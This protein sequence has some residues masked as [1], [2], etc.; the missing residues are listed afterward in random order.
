[1][2][3]PQLGGYLAVVVPLGLRL[4]VDP[5]QSYW[6]MGPGSLNLTFT[7]DKPMK[8][9][10]KRNPQSTEREISTEIPELN[11]DLSATTV[12]LL[13][14][15]GCVLTERDTGKGFV[16]TAVNLTTG[17]REVLA[18]RAA[19]LTTKSVHNMVEKIRQ[20]LVAGPGVIE[21]DR[22]FG[23]GVPIEKCREIMRSVFKDVLP[24][25][26]YTERKEQIS[27]A[28]HI[29]EAIHRRSVSLAEAEVGT[30]KSIGYLIPVII[31]KRSRLNSYWNMT[32]Y[33]GTPYVDMMNMPIVIATSS[34]ALQ[35]ALVD[36]VIPKLSDILLEA[37]VISR[38]IIA[39]LRKGRDHYLCRYK[40][41]SH[42]PFVEDPH[43]E[44]ILAVLNRY[45]SHVD[46]AEVDGLDNHTKRKISVPSSCSRTCPYRDSC[47]YLSFRESLESSDIDIQ[48][49]NHNYLLA[50]ALRRA[51]GG[52]PLI[53]N[54]QMVIFDEAHK[55]LSA[56]RTMYGEQFSL[57]QTLM[58]CDS[59]KTLFFDDKRVDVEIYNLSHHLGTQVRRLFL[60]LEKRLPKDPGDEASRFTVVLDKDRFR[61]L[62]NIR[63]AAENLI[64]LITSTKIVG[65]GG[66][67]S[68]QILNELRSISRMVAVLSNP[69]EQIIWLETTHKELVLHTV[70]KN[71]GKKLFD[72]LWS[73]GIPTILTS[74]TLSVGGD[75]THLR[76]M[77]GLDNLE[78]YK[79]I[80]TSQPS[81][82]NFR[83]NALTYISP[84]VLLPNQGNSDYI[85]SV[86]DEIERL[87]Y[88][89]HGH[90]VI[91]FTSYRAMD[92]VYQYLKERNLP[93]PL[94]RL[95]KGDV[96]T[97]ER[98]KESG[99]G[100]LFAA[101]SLWE[102][103]DIPGDALSLV[104]IVKLPFP[105]PDPISEYERSL[106]DSHHE[107]QQQVVLHET[108]IKTKQGQ[109]RGHRTET[110]TAVIAYLD[111]RLSPDG[112]YLAYFG[113]EV[114][115]DCQVTTDLAAV[116][117]FFNERKPLEY[118][119]T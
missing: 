76:K 45:G 24:A 58:T 35:K 79:V 81:P 65:T 10:N 118:F 14:A 102:G 111:S 97:V 115:L 64:G 114:F 30:G 112:Q 33:T 18:R 42:L 94:F 70:P 5:A 29:L 69:S 27:L 108:A 43:T 67:R 17:N 116:A 82:F 87:V 28:F 36:E 40:L 61:N 7:E 15:Y 72:D 90:A 91:L 96:R 11:F 50:D 74:G 12:P 117:K 46:L 25:F 105:V 51:E 99:N 41:N 66:G 98:F 56:A 88:A 49:C 83:D 71:L 52:K 47:A 92:K 63:K 95:E 77:L 57:K 75:F 26:G 8:F 53:P 9:T 54:Y 68:V 4:F 31:A 2:C 80:E 3:N 103:I 62:Q 60:A 110:D 85:L 37:G 23:D 34:I 59:V 84:N 20:S 21:T 100:V 104:V 13:T 38:P 55:L 119:L 106:Y 39:A 89:S 73:K 44:D 109:G 113:S 107:Y 16:Y 48:V 19:P 86:A 32:F 6:L 93:F 101:G 78:P 1:V 22:D